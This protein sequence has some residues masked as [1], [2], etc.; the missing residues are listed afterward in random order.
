MTAELDA[1]FNITDLISFK[2]LQ[3]GSS[4]STK[5]GSEYLHCND[6][7]VTNATYLTFFAL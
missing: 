4:E 2:D 5:F 3:I 1:A 6:L 7:L